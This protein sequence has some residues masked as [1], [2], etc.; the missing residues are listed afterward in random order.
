[1][2]NESTNYTISSNVEFGK[3]KLDART[4]KS[5]QKCNK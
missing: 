5:K 3:A 1:M 2:K 4:H